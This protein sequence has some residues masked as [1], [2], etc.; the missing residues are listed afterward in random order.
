MIMSTTEKKPLFELTASELE[1]ELSGMF[2]AF[3]ATYPIRCEVGV[4]LI[5]AQATTQRLAL[6]AFKQLGASG[7]GHGS[8]HEAPG[9]VFEAVETLNEFLLEGQPSRIDLVLWDAAGY[10]HGWFLNQRGL[11]DVQLG[12]CPEVVAKLAAALQTLSTCEQD[13]RALLERRAVS[14]A[15]LVR[16]SREKAELQARA[17]VES[18]SWLKK[19][20]SPTSLERELLS[21][22]F[23]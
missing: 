20:I 1:E 21:L 13:W 11:P 4:A 15:S 23:R 6:Q 19:L 10:I 2:N 3:S 14:L 16:L 22:G 12:S 9:P 8:G 5:A 17:K 18:Q 7:G